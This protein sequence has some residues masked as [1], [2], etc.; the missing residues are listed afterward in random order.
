MIA[1]TKNSLK[2]FSILTFNRGSEMED[3]LGLRGL[4]LFCFVAN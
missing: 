4:Y 3:T 2:N 1:G